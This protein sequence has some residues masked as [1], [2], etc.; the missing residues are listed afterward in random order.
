VQGKV[1]K[2]R[3]FLT[4]LVVT[5]LAAS[6]PAVHGQEQTV[7]GCYDRGSGTL[8]KVTGS[9]QCNPDEIF[10]SWTAPKDGQWSYPAVPWIKPQPP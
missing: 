3:F 7:Y 2:Y 9:D 4:S 1:V 10:I 8:R 6:G 5:V